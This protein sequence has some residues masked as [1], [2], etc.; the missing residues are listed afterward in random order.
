MKSWQRYTVLGLWLSLM[1]S[2]W[3]YVNN[4]SQSATGLLQSWLNSFSS[5]RWGPFLLLGIFVIRPIF[6]LPISILNVFAGFLFGAFW[7]SLYGLIATLISASI[8]YFMGR[9]FGQGLKPKQLQSKLIQRMQQQSFE[10]ILLS[11]LIF[12]PGDLVNY[13]AGFLRISFLAFFF[14]T[15]LGGMPSLLMTTFAGASIEGNFEF[16]GFRLNIWYLLASVALLIFSLISSYY[17]K[18]QSD[19]QENSSEK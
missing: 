9:F 19:L 4:S 16:T 2:F 18:K 15:A 7:G 6:L 13:A 17:L 3:L 5:S 8:P 11:R 14:A 10:T 1:I 12:V